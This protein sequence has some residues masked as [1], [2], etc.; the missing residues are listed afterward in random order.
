MMQSYPFVVGLVLLFCLA[1]LGYCKV[2]ARYASIKQYPFQISVEMD[3]THYCSGAI[4]GDQWVVT[5]KSCIPQNTTEVDRVKVRAGS[6]Y[7]ASG[8]ALHSVKKLMRFKRSSYDMYRHMNTDISMIKV[9][10]PF[11]YS[12]YVQWSNPNLEELTTKLKFSAAGYAK[13]RMNVG[14][15]IA[16]DGLIYAIV[17]NKDY[18]KSNG[19]HP[20]IVSQLE[21]SS[22][23]IVQTMA[24]FIPRTF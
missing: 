22:G 20:V 14:T 6:S 23:T 11:N 13:D 10:I 16:A 24:E 1:R 21:N 8:G 7:L 5:A 2:G 19:R 15:P 9:E 12:P 18:C 4:V 3:N 17:I